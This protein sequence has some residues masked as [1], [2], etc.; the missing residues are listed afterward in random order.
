MGGGFPPLP[1]RT[2]SGNSSAGA[3]RSPLRGPHV[4]RGRGRGRGSPGPA[5]RPCPTLRAAV[6]SRRTVRTGIV[7]GAPLPRRRAAPVPMRAPGCPATSPV[8][9]PRRAG[10]SP[11]GWRPA[12]PPSGRV[13][14]SGA[15]RAR[16]VRPL[17]PSGPR[18]RPRRRPVAACP[19]RAPPQPLRAPHHRP[20]RPWRPLWPPW[21][22]QPPGSAAP[23]RSGRTQGPER[24]QTAPGRPPRPQGTRK[25][26]HPWEGWPPFMPC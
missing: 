7:A 16:T 5:G 2:P 14:R 4:P 24:P 11:P 15:H 9:L 26:G 13:R 10:T 23:G 19:S 12:A 21:T 3:V 22:P 1:T 25:G 6:M 8:R 18:A 17:R 20:T